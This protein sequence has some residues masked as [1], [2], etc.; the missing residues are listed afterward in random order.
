MTGCC[1]PCGGKLGK[2]RILH[3][4]NI[5]LVCIVYC[6]WNRK[7]YCQNCKHCR[8]DDKQLFLRL[9]RLLRLAFFL[10]FF[11]GNRQPLTKPFGKLGHCLR[12]VRDAQGKAA[13][14]RRLLLWRDLH[15]EG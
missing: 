4:L 12:S 2:V 13:H 10:L 7:A 11:I 5:I 6:F 8:S 14:Q 3:I 1:L 15:A 9:C